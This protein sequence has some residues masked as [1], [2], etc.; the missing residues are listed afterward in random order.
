MSVFRPEWLPDLQA[1]NSHPY[2][3]LHSPDDIISINQ[4]A[5]EAVRQ[6]RAA[7]A[8]AK[9]QTYK[10]GHGWREDPFGHIRRGVEWLES[11]TR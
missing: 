10:G 8:T 7:K 11:Q 9:L 6:L 5:R 3:I 4:H 1:A 2:Y